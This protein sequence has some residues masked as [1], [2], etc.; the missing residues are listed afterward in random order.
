M[1]QQGDCAGPSR[2]ACRRP[3]RATTHSSCKH[4]CIAEGPGRPPAGPGRAA[5]APCGRGPLQLCSA[6]GCAEAG[7]A[8]ALTPALRPD[9]CSIGGVRT[10]A[11]TRSCCARNMSHSMMRPSRNSHMR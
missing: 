2:S 4:R 3:A 10:H 9:A 6:D 7:S 1:P 5:P 8:P 11:K